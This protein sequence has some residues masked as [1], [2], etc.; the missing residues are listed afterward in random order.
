VDGADYT[1]WADNYLSTGNP[2]NSQG[3]WSVGN[4]TEDDVVDGADYTV[5]ADHYLQGCAGA[6]VPEPCSA[7][8]ILV[9][10]PLLMRRQ[11]RVA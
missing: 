2:P 4:F 5:W 7:L 3:G 9:A 10:A 8:A 11:K 1:V 6:A